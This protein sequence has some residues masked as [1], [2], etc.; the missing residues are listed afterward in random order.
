[1]GIQQ[2]NKTNSKIER[3]VQGRNSTNETSTEANWKIKAGCLTFSS[4]YCLEQK[5]LEQLGSSGS[6]WILLIHQMRAASPPP[7]EKHSQSLSL[8]LCVAI[9]T[10]AHTVFLLLLAALESTFLLQFGSPSSLTPGHVLQSLVLEFSLPS[11]SFCTN[12]LSLMCK[13]SWQLTFVNLFRNWEGPGLF[14]LES[15]SQATRQSS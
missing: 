6:H 8:D 9:L 15:Q 13:S 14:L 10:S 5:S 11:F 1:M 4:P 7:L 2:Q 12:G 3:L